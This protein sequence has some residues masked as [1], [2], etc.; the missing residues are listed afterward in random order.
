MLEGKS[1]ATNV[2]SN[3]ID[4]HSINLWMMEQRITNESIPKERMMPFQ[5]VFL[6][7]LKNPMMTN[8]NKRWKIDRID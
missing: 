4:R 2:R 7:K 5:R 1:L 3:D 8:F 6:H